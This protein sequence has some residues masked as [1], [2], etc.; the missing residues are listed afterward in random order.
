MRFPEDTLTKWAESY[1][2][3]E[4]PDCSPEYLA[5]SK[6]K[7]N[8][9]YYGYERILGAITHICTSMVSD[10]L[11]G[12]CAKDYALIEGLTYNLA[13]GSIIGSPTWNL[14]ITR[15]ID[16]LIDEI[17]AN[18]HLDWMDVEGRKH[19]FAEDSWSAETVTAFLTE[20]KAYMN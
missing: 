13:N 18:R 1:R 14:T 15:S 20:L 17:A 5:N 11:G 2:L 7:N 6:K 19:I 9:T 3:N 16:W 10:G 12:E 4:G 8:L